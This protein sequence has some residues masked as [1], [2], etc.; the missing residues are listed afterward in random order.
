MHRD[1]PHNTDDTIDSRD[2]IE[3][4]EELEAEREELAEALEDAQAVQ[5]TRSGLGDAAFLSEADGMVR[6][7]TRAL[8]D[9]A[10]D[11]DHELSALR[12]F[13]GEASGY[14]D[15]WE[16]GCA[17]IRDSHFEDYAQELADDIGAIPADARWPTTCIDWKQAA[18]ELQMDYTSAEFDGVTYW[19][20]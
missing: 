3:R 9:W 15:D 20:R 11:N 7:A 5:T 18:R 16:H 4:I 12:A 2:V 17:L 8:V 19:L 10:S 13:A 14:A 6:D 1:A